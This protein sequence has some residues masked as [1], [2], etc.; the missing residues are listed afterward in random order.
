MKTF[1]PGK[2][3]TTRSACDYEC[4]FNV[5]IISRT[6]RTVKAEVRGEVKTCKIYIFEGVESIK[7]FGSYSMAPIFRAE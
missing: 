2:T 3:Y 7:P 5:K 4:V 6:A 1:T